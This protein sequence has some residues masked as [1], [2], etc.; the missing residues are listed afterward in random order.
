MPRRGAVWRCGA[1]LRFRRCGGGPIVF[2]PDG[3]GQGRALRW[4]RRCPQEK[5]EAP[6]D[7]RSRPVFPAA[8]RRRSPR[9]PVVRRCKLRPMLALQY[10]G[11][12]TIN[13]S[14]SGA[15]IRVEGGRPLREGEEVE[16]AIDWRNTCL[17]PAGA[18]IRARICRV[19]E[20][21][22][23][24]LVGVVFSGVPALAVQELPA[25]L[26]RAA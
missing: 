24:T 19:S 12:E 5:R 18:V 16:L 3:G 20:H 14:K 23:A 4:I 13:V 9:H 25:A 26:A 21:D 7:V 10:R 11:G 2:P 1:V 17:V 8:D 15:L 6:M 22:G